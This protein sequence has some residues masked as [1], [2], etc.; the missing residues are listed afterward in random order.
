M[1]NRSIL[2]S[3]G[4]IGGAGPMAGALLFQKVIQ[5]CQE[6]YACQ[7]DGDFPFI[8]LLNI[9]FEDMLHNVHRQRVQEQLSAALSILNQ[10][11][12]RI[13]AIACNTLHEFL[14]LKGN[15]SFIFLH[16]IEETARALREAQISKPLVLCSTTSARCQL[17]KR[18]FDCS[19]PDRDWQNEIQCLIDKILSGKQTPSDTEQLAK[20][21]NQM[22]EAD[23]RVGLVLG[24]TEFSLFENQ[25]S[26]KS[27]GLDQRFELFDPNQIIAK[28]ICKSIFKN[29]GD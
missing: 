5:C 2:P 4:I 13:A 25:Y 7:E 21:L 6:E 16:I 24:C 12:I 17:H 14:E 18:Y 3:L 23:S 10:N 19:Y 15:E 20:Q 26:L 1:K 27:H 28:A 22:L 8:M 11:Q 29:K 9:P